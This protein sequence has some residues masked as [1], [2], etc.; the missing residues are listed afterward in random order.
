[1]L[2]IRGSID[3]SINNM[4]SKNKGLNPSDII[5]T[6]PIIGPSADAIFVRNSLIPNCL[7]KCPLGDCDFLIK[8][9]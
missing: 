9:R 8:N 5:N 2:N 7:P 6:P 3:E 4:E 1:M